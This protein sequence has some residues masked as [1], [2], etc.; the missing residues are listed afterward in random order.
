V[1]NG[2]T[3]RIGRETLPQKFPDFRQKLTQA[4]RLGHKVVAACI[5]CFGL[6]VA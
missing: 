2:T 3:M 6:V 1:A 5:A 4:I